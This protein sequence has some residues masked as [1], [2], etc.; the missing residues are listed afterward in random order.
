MIYTAKKWL[1]NILSNKET[2][3]YTKRYIACM[4]VGFL[5]G[6]S[7]HTYHLYKDCTNKGFITLSDKGFYCNER[8]G[9]TL[10]GK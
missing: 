9:E 3:F 10:N 6:V 7:L 2:I 8:Y 5:L 4:M 1:K